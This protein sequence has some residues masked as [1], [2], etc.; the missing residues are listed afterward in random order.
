MGAAVGGKVGK[1]IGQGV[2]LSLVGAFDGEAVESELVG[3]LLAKFVG[4]LVGSGAS[5]SGLVGLTV[6]LEFVGAIDGKT[7][8]NAVGPVL[9]GAALVGDG[10]ALVGINVGDSVELAVGYI[11][12]TSTGDPFG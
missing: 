6:G 3:E 12:S 7:V 1:D 4:L 8:G 10:Y 9:L 11:E 5:F 2:G